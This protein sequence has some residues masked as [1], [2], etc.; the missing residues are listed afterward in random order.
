MKTKTT[1][2]RFDVERGILNC[3]SICEDLD[4]VLAVWDDLTEDE[5][6]NALIGISQLYQIKFQRT[7]DIFEQCVSSKNI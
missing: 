6:Q 5:K 2:T 3:W 4:A 7:F 1:N